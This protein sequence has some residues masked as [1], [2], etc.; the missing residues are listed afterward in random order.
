MHGD[1]H[2]A[3]SLAQ[4]GAKL[5]AVRFTRI[6]A[7]VALGP[8]VTIAAC[9]SRGPLDITIIEV[10]DGGA[11]VDATFD[12]SEDADATADARDGAADAPREATIVDCGRCLAQQCNQQI[13]Q[14]VQNPTCQQTFQCAVQQCFAGGNASPSCL[15]QCANDPQGT[16]GVLR[17]LTCVTG[18]CGPDCTSVLAL[19]GGLGGGGGGGGGGRDGGDPVQSDVPLYSPGE[20]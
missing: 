20:P 6:A 10:G 12:A 8:L 16:A 13:L 19:L 1:G 17:I 2:A 18:K 7:L 11:D 14:C 3:R 15:F 4:R 9:G 5:R